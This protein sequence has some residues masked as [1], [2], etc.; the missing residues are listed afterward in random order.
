MKFGRPVKDIDL[1]ELKSLME[2]YPSLDETA[3][4]FDCSQDTISRAIDVGFNMT[5]AEFRQHYMARTKLNLKRVAIKKAIEGD[6]RMLIHCLRALTNMD[7]RVENQIDPSSKTIDEL[8]TEAQKII[9][10]R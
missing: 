2:F 1:E 7:E 5:F 9:S 8:I 6:S 3:G 4:W 10:S